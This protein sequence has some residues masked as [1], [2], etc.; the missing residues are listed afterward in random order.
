MTND[1]EKHQHI[2]HS[3]PTMLLWGGEGGGKKEECNSTRIAEDLGGFQLYQSFIG[4]LIGRIF[5][6]SGSIRAVILSGFIGGLVPRREIGTVVIAD[7]CGLSAVWCGVWTLILV[8]GYS[9]DAELS[10][11]SIGDGP[12][13]MRSFVWRISAKIMRWWFFIALALSIHS[14]WCRFIYRLLLFLVVCLDAELYAE[15][16]GA[17]WDLI[18]WSIMQLW[19][20]PIV[21]YERVSSNQLLDSVLNQLKMS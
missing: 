10:G 11:G 6:K 7:W 16:V 19:V 20:N 8:N 9:S 4:V 18:S 13:P 5:Q 17:C 21:R 1:G 12:H 15:S 3:A 2:P 14:I